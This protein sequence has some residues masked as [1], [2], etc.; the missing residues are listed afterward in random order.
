M[1]RW[2]ILLTA[3]WLM[4]ALAWAADAQ[5]RQTIGQAT[6]T[7]RNGDLNGRQSPD[8]HSPKI[9]WFPDGET[10]SIYEV[11]GD[12]ALTDGSEYGTCWVNINY[13]LTEDAGAYT[14]T[15]NGRLR[16]R[17]TPDGTTIGWLKPGQTVDVLSIF[18]GWA[19]T[20]NGWVMAEFLQANK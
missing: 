16:V 15:A 17:S 1:K 3:V 13:L 19:R 2:L 11:N 14:V 18:G 5:E 12:W 7:V 20:D 6:V 9:A 4:L 8:I 10:I